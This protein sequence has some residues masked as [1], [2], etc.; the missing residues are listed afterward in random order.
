MSPSGMLAVAHDRA[1]LP[2]MTPVQA[3]GRPFAA[4]LAR[5]LVLLRAGPQIAVPR[6]PAEAPAPAQAAQAPTA[7]A[8]IVSGLPLRRPAR[9]ARGH[10]ETG[11]PR[12]RKNHGTDHD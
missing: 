12:H 11:N 5:A 1:P 2:A 9:K 10:A 3:P 4:D 6:T 7:F 8:G